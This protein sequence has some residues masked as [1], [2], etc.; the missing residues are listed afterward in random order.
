MIDV[1]VRAG[2]R[3]VAKPRRARQLGKVAVTLLRVGLAV[4]FIAG[5]AAKL[6]GDAQLVAMFEDIGA[7]QWFRLAIGA[8]EVAG[9]V[10]L[11]V[12]RV[13]GLAAAG[14]AALMAGAV[15]TNVVVLAIAPWLPLA[16]GV[17]AAVV[18]MTRR[19]QVVA[20]FHT[21]RYSTPAAR[22]GQSL[23]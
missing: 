18:A 1:G 9:G 7:G 8:L 11:L 14:L 2:D 23:S 19:G 15:V 5:G 16:V 20:A 10:G 12:P 21:I 22:S 17:L 13:A 6:L 3:S 4:Q